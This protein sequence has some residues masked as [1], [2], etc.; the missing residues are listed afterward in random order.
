MTRENE[1]P[2]QEHDRQL[3]RQAAERITREPVMVV[4][5][6]VRKVVYHVPHRTRLGAEGG[7]GSA[8]RAVSTA[9][10]VL[11]FVL[12][13]PVALVSSLLSEVGIEFAF[14]PK[15]KFFVRGNASCAALPLA[16]ALR[17]AGGEAWL[18][19]SDSQVA[20]LTTGSLSPRVLWHGSGDRSPEVEINKSNLHW[21]DGSRIGIDLDIQEK[22][23]VHN[24]TA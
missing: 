24:G 16:D 12:Y 23:R 2:P 21:S 20:L 4:H 13:L 3:I 15:G 1:T 10:R 8:R 19:W 6:R 14:W 18:A 7:R 11:L 9:L 17:D 22:T 5:L